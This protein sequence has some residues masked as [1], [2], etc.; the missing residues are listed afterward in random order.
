M[1]GRRGLDW[2]VCLVAAAIAPTALLG[3]AGYTFVNLNAQWVS[4]LGFD[5]T[6]ST[7]LRGDF[8]AVSRLERR[9]QGLPGEAG[10]VVQ[11]TNRSLAARGRHASAME[12]APRNCDF[13]A[14]VLSGDTADLSPAPSRAQL[15]LAVRGHPGRTERN[16]TRVRRE[17]DVDLDL[18]LRLDP[19]LAESRPK[20]MHDVNRLF[21]SGSPVSD[22]QSSP[23]L[24]RPSS[25]GSNSIA[26]PLPAKDCDALRP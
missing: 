13:L 22:E 23:S 5:S 6:L 20:K 26:R 1:R 9:V 17:R 11:P 21:L 3:A 8:P 19:S 18:L 15:I 24:A 7:E 4:E 10:F 2:T 12:S 14:P 16:A 25:G